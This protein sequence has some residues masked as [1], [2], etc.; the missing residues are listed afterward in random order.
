MIVDSDSEVSESNEANNDRIEP[1]EWVEARPIVIFDTDFA[2][3]A[4]PDGDGAGT[5]VCIDP[6]S[7]LL[8][9]GCDFYLSLTQ[10]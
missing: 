2:L 1:F 7:G 5:P 10:I 9:A 8:V 6:T 3:P 4:M